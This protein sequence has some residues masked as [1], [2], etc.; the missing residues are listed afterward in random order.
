[1][2]NK[3]LLGL[4]VLSLSLVG[5]SNKAE[6]KEAK[7]IDGTYYYVYFADVFY[8]GV[9][10]RTIITM[11]YGKNYPIESCGNIDIS[12]YTYQQIVVTGF[13]FD[14]YLGNYDK[15]QNYITKKGTYEFE[16]F[17]N[18]FVVFGNSELSSG[19]IKDGAINLNKKYS[20]GTIRANLFVTEQYAKSHN[21]K[22]VN[23]K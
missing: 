4:L 12:Y 10:E 19:N 5:C 7:T 1:M 18:D 17:E 23:P 2:K 22:I 15:G 9:A 21:Y 3:S 11:E 16:C 8:P 20:D 6:S 14:L 13:S